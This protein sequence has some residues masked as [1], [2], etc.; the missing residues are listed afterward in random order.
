MLRYIRAFFL[1]L[2]LTLKGEQITLASQSDY[3]ELARWVENTGQLVRTV[4]KTCESNGMDKAK[5]KAVVIQADGRTMD[6]ETILQTVQ[7]HAIEE[8]P[9]LLRFGGDQGITAI[10]ATNLNDQYYV[11]RLSE[12]LNSKLIIDVIKPLLEH[13]ESIP[14]DEK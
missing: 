11:M 7:Y 8:Y 5:R 13:L 4:F 14:S 10:Y 3:P 1:A 2:K 6:M 9:H 12:N